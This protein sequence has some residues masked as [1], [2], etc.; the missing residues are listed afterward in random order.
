MRQTVLTL[1]SSLALAPLCAAPASAADQQICSKFHTSESGL[2]GNFWV[3]CAVPPDAD[4]GQ[5]LVGTV[6]YDRTPDGGADVTLRVEP[7]PG[8]DE[9]TC[10]AVPTF[11][12]VN[13]AIHLTADVGTWNGHLPQYPNGSFIT[14]GC[15]VE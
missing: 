1:I 9:V 7:V 15:H 4:P 14:C 2:D 11:T 8:C 10:D 12:N 13:H 3:D 6:I 5:P